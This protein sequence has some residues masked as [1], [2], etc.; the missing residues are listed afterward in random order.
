M[1]NFSKIIANKKNKIEGRNREKVK[2]SKDELAK[3]Q[4]AFD[5]ESLE[6]KPKTK[7]AKVETVVKT[8]KKQE[9]ETALKNLKPSKKEDEPVKKKSIRA[10]IKEK[11]KEMEDLAS[12]IASKK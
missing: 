12:L 7:K 3:N 4:I 8:E 5:L 1:K 6:Q 2:K 9:K 10:E 11:E